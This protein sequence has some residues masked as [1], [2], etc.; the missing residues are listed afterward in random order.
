MTTGLI[1]MSPRNRYSKRDYYTKPRQLILELGELGASGSLS[2]AITTAKQSVYMT[3]MF[4]S[5][6]YR[7]CRE[8]AKLQV[9][10][11]MLCVVNS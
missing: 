2:Q 10:Q 5:K 3:T 9:Q 8:V 4:Y 1:T 6:E 7:R 11:S